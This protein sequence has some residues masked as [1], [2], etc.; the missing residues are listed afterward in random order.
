MS[1]NY[2]K[3]PVSGVDVEILPDTPVDV[4]IPL[5]TVADSDYTG[6]LNSI[7]NFDITEQRFA[8]FVNEALNTEESARKLSE[9]LNSQ[10]DNPLIRALMALQPDSEKNLKNALVESSRKAVQGEIDLYRA[11]IRGVEDRLTQLE[12]KFGYKPVVPTASGNALNPLADKAKSKGNLI[13]PERKAQ[14]EAIPGFMALKPVF[15]KKEDGNYH[16]TATG[17][18]EGT[19][20]FSNIKNGWKF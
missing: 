17:H 11:N 19:D 1:K 18:T 15:V 5:V 3:I 20:Y 2:Q 9:E 8:G 12:A 13:T 16:V 4:E 10:K 6:M 7:A 14:L